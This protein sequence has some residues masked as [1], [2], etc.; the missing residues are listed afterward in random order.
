MAR[1]PEAGIERLK[2]E[3]SVQHPVE[4]SAE[5]GEAKRTK[6]KARPSPVAFD[7]DDQALVSGSIAYNGVGNIVSQAFGQSSL[8]YTYDNRNRLAS[9]PLAVATAR[10]AFG[11]MRFAY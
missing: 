10:L 3:V 1:I 7:P 2:D 11:A 9:V 4:A 5:D 8:N 6:D